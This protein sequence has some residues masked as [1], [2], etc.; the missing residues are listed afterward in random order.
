MTLNREEF[1]SLPDELKY[2]LYQECS[3]QIDYLKG[4]VSGLVSKVHS[5]DPT[6]PPATEISSYAAVTKRGENVVGKIM[7]CLQKKI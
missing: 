7:V 1:L 5:T 4:L 3:N 2:K 6:K